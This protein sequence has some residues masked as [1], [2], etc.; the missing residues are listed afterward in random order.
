MGSTTSTEIGGVRVFKVE[1]KSSRTSASGRSPP[2]ASCAGEPWQSRSR[3]G[4]GGAPSA[5]GISHTW[6]Y[7]D[8]SNCLAS[9]GDNAAHGPWQIRYRVI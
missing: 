8:N 5:F 1:P 3:S 6:Y 7:L 9:S 2:D 4:S